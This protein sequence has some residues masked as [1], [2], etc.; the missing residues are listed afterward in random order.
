MQSEAMLR[1]CCARR[2]RY[3]S[4]HSWQRLSIQRCCPVPYAI[5]TQAEVLTEALDVIGRSRS[6]LA[7]LRLEASLKNISSGIRPGRA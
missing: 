6:L 2:V 1:A 4:Q 3:V 7:I 5:P